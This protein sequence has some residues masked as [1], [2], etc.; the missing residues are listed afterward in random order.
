MFLAGAATGAISMRFGI[1]GWL[2]PS[3]AAV[4]PATRDAVLNRF[5]TELDLDR[6]QTEKLSLV[7]DDYR[8]YYESLQEQLDDLRSTGK[9]RI[10][11]ILNPE[12][13]IKFQKMMTD[14]A[15]QLAGD[16]K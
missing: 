11:Q 3:A 5:K 10:L 1:H 6:A 8:Q 2:H 15:P 14:L 13:R 12:Q 16:E 4:R 9:E 7:L